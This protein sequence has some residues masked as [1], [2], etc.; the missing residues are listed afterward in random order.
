[1]LSVETQEAQYIVD[2]S[3]EY[4][5]EELILPCHSCSMVNESKSERMTDQP[6]YLVG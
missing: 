2:E 6:A 1:M 5:I 3:T 4:A